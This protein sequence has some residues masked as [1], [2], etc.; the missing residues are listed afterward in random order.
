MVIGVFASKDVK[1][2]T[3]TTLKG[4]SQLDAET[5]TVTDEMLRKEFMSKGS[6]DLPKPS[7]FLK[8]NTLKRGNEHG[9]QDHGCASC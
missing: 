8:D 3:P 7:K 6:L 9:W 2:N 5:V 1:V 4:H